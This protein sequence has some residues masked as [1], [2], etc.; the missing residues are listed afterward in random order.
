MHCSSESVPPVTV[1]SF[2]CSSFWSRMNKCSWSV[3]QSGNGRSGEVT[4]FNYAF[5]FNDGVDLFV[6]FDQRLYC[7]QNNPPKKKN[8]T[9]T[10]TKNPQQNN[11]PKQKQT[12]TKN[13]FK[14]T[15]HTKTHTKNKQKQQE[16]Y[17]QQE[18]NQTTTK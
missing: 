16:T 5:L 3:L 12:N 9:I 18:T 11:N 10:H 13:Y 15:P 17:K 4:D 1:H 6:V 7:R 14:K 2:F 8:P